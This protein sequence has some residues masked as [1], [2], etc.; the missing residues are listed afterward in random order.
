MRSKTPKVIPP[1]RS[2]GK[3]DTMTKP[4]ITNVHADSYS[5]IDGE[6]YSELS[7]SVGASA[8]CAV[9][10]EDG[11]ARYH[12]WVLL[13]SN[14]LYG[15]RQCIERGMGRY[16]H[17]Y[18]T[19]YKNSLVK[20]EP[21]EAERDW[22]ARGG[23]STRYLDAA[24]P[25]NAR[26]LDL[27]FHVVETDNL[28]ERARAEVEHRQ[29]LRIEAAAAEYREQL[30]RDNGPAMY[31]AIMTSLGFLES[32]SDPLYARIAKSTQL[33]RDAIKFREGP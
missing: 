2:A 20:R 13:G 15:P 10:W 19:I 11:A 29:R 4:I 17:A 16:S 33:L 1:S 28:I 32:G 3:G 23:F 27:V 18:G 24:K 26:I 21:K 30:K 5:F 7:R 22:I 6:S 9:G 12:V 14:P 8:K 31:E 25:A